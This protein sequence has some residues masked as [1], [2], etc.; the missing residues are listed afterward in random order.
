LNRQRL[1]I[2]CLMAPACVVAV[3]GAFSVVVNN[4]GSWTWRPD[5]VS[6]PEAVATGNY[7][8]VMRQIESGA[9]PNLR[10]GIR[11]GVLTGMPLRLTPLETAVWGRNVLMVRLL[12]DHGAVIGPTSLVTLKC[13]N[14][15]NGDQAVR[16]LLDALPTTIEKPCS[17]VELPVGS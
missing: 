16:A 13:L 15:Q 10:D 2:V 17:E 4:R 1:L 14:E 6:M 12:L 8:E 7:A 9:D 3:V 11:A 5:D